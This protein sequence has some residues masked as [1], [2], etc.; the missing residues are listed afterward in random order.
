MNVTLRGWAGGGHR[1]AI[2]VATRWPEGGHR[3]RAKAHLWP[4]CGHPEKPVIPACSLTGWPLDR[5]IRLKT[6]VYF[7]L[8]VG[9]VNTGT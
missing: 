2:R 4:P 3:G 5:L 6:F 1:V 9:L 8:K 7:I